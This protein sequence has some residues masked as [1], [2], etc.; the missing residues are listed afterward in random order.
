MIAPEIDV[1]VAHAL[2]ERQKVVR[3][4]VPAGTTAREAALRSGLDQFFPGL[5]LHKGPIG[6]FGEVVRD[7]QVLAPGDRVELYRRLPIDP[8]EARR[9]R[10]EDERRGRR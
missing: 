4:R 8:R 7:D 3:L 6:V 2:P 9:A 1:E 5:D 10:V